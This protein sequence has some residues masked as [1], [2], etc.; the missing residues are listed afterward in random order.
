MSDRRIPKVDEYVRLVGTLL[1]IKVIPPPPPPPPQTVYWF[2]DTT[3]HYEARG[4]GHVMLTGS[5]FN[6]FYGRG[7]C[8]KS[9]IQDAVEAMEVYDVPGVEFVV[10]ETTTKAGYRVA[11]LGDNLYAKEFVQLEESSLIRSEETH[12]DVWSSVRGELTRDN[13]GEQ[14]D[15]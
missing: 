4:N 10:V 1:E 12:A 9:A 6:N 11:A 13:K 15:E 3:A 8:V 14:N 5:E 7:D 2:E